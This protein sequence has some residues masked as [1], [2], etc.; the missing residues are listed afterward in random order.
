M[1][2]PRSMRKPRMIVAIGLS[3]S[4][5]AVYYLLSRVDA[6]RLLSALM[7]ADPFILSACIVTKGAVLALNAARTQML[8][9][10]LRRYHF[11]ECFLAWL[12]GYVTDNLLPFRLG[13][14]VRIDLLARSGCISRSSTIAVVGL[15]RLIELASLLILLAIAAPLMAID[16]GNATRLFLALGILVCCV[17]AA[18]WVATHPS[19]ILRMVAAL[20]RPLNA[21]AQEWLAGHAQRFVHGFGALRSRSMMVSVLGVTLLARLIG[22]LTIQCWLWAF[23]LSLPV[24][25][26]L[27]VLLFI[28]VGTMIPSSP[29]FVGTFHVACV[30]ALELMGVAPELATSVAIAG[31]FMGTVPWT[32]GG[33]FVSLPGIRR[34]WQRRRESVRPIEP[35]VS[36]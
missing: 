6:Q 25:A 10:P 20:I 24:Y 5:I 33:L 23:G 18:L 1:S 13:E 29:G 30:Y 12:S 4:G 31:H 11:S 27:L 36:T 28:S 32:V 15:D 9:L 7:Y 8:L 22:M 35:V 21:T 19:A 16:L 3:L 17:V 14:L 26:P 34:V 2:P